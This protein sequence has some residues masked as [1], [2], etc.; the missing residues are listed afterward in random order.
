MQTGGNFFA[1]CKFSI[2]QPFS[3][4]ALVFTC[5]QYNSFENTVQKGEIACYVFYLFGELLPFLP[6]PTNLKMSFANSFSLEESKIYCF[7]KG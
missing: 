1:Y 6:F 2:Y 4:Q 3:K 7:R 5:L